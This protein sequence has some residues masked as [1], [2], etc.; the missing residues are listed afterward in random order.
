[1]N[2]FINGWLI[3]FRHQLVKSF[4]GS[5]VGEVAIHQALVAELKLVFVLPA[6]IAIMMLMLM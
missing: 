6:M 1:M 2:L 4:G 3:Y 5:D